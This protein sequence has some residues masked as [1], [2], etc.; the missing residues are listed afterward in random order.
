MVQNHKILYTG[1]RRNTTNSIGI[2]D[3]CSYSLGDCFLGDWL[4][5]GLN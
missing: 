4:A 1:L 2:P 5:D 3:Q